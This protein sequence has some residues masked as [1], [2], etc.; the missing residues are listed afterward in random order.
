[1]ASWQLSP[2]HKTFLLQYCD[3]YDEAND[4]GRRKLREK[5]ANQLI[6]HFRITEKEHVAD[7]PGVGSSQTFLALPRLTH[8]LARHGLVVRKG[9][10]AARRHQCR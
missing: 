9:V 2:A 7:V 1:M 3:D 8:Y 6:E 5:A 10:E 4:A